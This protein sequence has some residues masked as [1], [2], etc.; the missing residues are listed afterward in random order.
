MTHKIGPEDGTVPQ[1]L[2]E[3][4]SPLHA[5][6]QALWDGG[7][8]SRWLGPGSTII[9]GRSEQCDIRIDHSSVSRQHAQLTGGATITI[10]DLGSSNGVR[11]GGTRIEPGK[12]VAVGPGDVVEVGS[13]VVVIQP[14]KGTLRSEPPGK[15]Q[16]SAVQ[17][18]AEDSS[19]MDSVLRLVELVAQSDLSVVIL[20]ETGVGKSVTAKS[21][22][23]QSP[24]A[25][26]PFVSLNCTAFPEALLESELFGYERGAFTGA[27]QSKP[28]LIETAQGGT[29][30]L[31]EIGDMPLATQA[32]LLSVIENHE[33]IRLGSVKPHKVD[34][35]FLAATNRDL[36][37]ALKAGQF[38]SD[39]Y[40]RLNGITV[41]IPPLR[42]RG[43]E[44]VPLAQLFVEQLCQ[45]TGR[46]PIELGPAAC[47]SL[48]QHDW[49]GNI[50][51]LRNTMER[52]T[53]LCQ[54][55]TILPEHLHLEPPAGT[56]EL[57]S[58]AIPSDAEKPLWNE[59]ER[60]ERQRIIAALDAHKGNQTQAAKAL[61]ISRRT[62]ISRIDRYQLPRPRKDKRSR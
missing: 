17:P 13:A 62:L 47:Q 41:T 39:L 43:P 12:P 28:G 42:E 8:V 51:E 35:R 1:V 50:R 38:R 22:H 3:A 61:G 49:P 33:V 11:V 34:V 7:A 9:L 15:Q 46:E 16:P 10:E 30:L 31:D 48:Q 36:E 18:S 29:V 60:L 55:S 57:G 19:P 44:V 54:G 26:K 58:S 56:T 21:I 59:V 2:E 40:Y 20:G 32:K 25:A 53:A 23:A 27:T 14:P 24:R 45:R 4:A 37:A 6:L 5:R 52:A